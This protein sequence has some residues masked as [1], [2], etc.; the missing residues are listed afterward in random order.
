MDVFV[1]IYDTTAWTSR[2]RIL[3]IPQTMV[4]YDHFW[5]AN[6]LHPTDTKLISHPPWMAHGLTS[7]LPLPILMDY[8]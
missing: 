5:L 7:P 3:H 4:Y 2:E 8:A 6:P 1:I